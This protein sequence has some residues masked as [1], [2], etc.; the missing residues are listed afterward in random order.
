MDWAGFLLCAGFLAS[1]LVGIEWARPAASGG[2]DPLLLVAAVAAVLFFLATWTWFRRT[3][4]PLLRFGAL[5]VPS[6][7]VT[8]IGGAVY[9]M[10]ISAVPFLLPLMFQL[11]FGWSPV[12]AG[13]FVLLLFAGNV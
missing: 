2:V 13:S 9:R 7:R 8:N 4:H 1:L 5:R 3:P 6:F 10:I 12:R 11:G